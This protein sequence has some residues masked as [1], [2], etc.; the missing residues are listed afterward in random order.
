M[1]PSLYVWTFVAIVSNLP[2]CSNEDKDSK[3]LYNFIS[4]QT[5]SDIRPVVNWTDTLHLGL[6]CFIVSVNEFDGLSGKLSLTLVFNVYWTDSN[7]SWNPDDYGGIAN[8]LLKSEDIWMPPLVF[9]E[10]FNSI[11]ELDVDNSRVWVNHDGNVLW[12]TGDVMQVVCSVDMTYFPFDSQI[13]TITAS[14]VYHSAKELTLFAKDSQ[15]NTQHFKENS[16]WHYISGNI[17]PSSLDDGPSLLTFAFHFKRRAEFFLVYIILPVIF[18][19]QL[20]ILVF[21]MPVSSGERTSVCITTF[22]SFVVYMQIVNGHVPP[23]SKPIAYIYY[24]LLFV[25]A[26]SSTIMFLCIISSKIHNKSTQVP[27]VLRNAIKSTSCRRSSLPRKLP[28]DTY[29]KNRVSVSS[30][31]DT[32]NQTSQD[33]DV[34]LDN[35]EVVTWGMVG[36]FFDKVCLI[37]LLLIY[38]T[39]SLITFFRLFDNT[40]LV[41]KR[42][43][44]F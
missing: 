34:E 26:Y 35:G 29:D 15:I 2:L 3:A 38:W 12:T 19:C 11:Q 24:Y 37:C 28:K 44:E 13:C 10:S 40:G 7:V 4:S 43:T 9:Q 41:T 21:V 20:N 17:L 32:G 42:V 16:Q 30:Y 8:L 33:A 1:L 14:S 5:N 6:S 31:V 23:S 36:D 39:F 22:L 25:M 18:L 27:D